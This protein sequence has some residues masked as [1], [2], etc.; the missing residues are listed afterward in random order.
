MDLI[1]SLKCKTPKAGT[2]KGARKGFFEIVS[3]IYR[4]VTIY[5]AYLTPTG[6]RIRHQNPAD[7]FAGPCQFR[8]AEPG[9]QGFTGSIFC[10]GVDILC[11]A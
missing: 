1:S 5:S 7:L 6:S 10:H 9:D 4:M 3:L 2:A 8:V 11:C